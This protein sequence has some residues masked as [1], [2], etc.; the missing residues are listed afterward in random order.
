MNVH[1]INTN[2]LCNAIFIELK[3]I[4]IT[5]V[6]TL[7]GYAQIQNSVQEASPWLTH[8]HDDLRAAIHSSNRIIH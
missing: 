8:L 3:R 6:Y 1:L 7:A 2:I 5:C 4:L